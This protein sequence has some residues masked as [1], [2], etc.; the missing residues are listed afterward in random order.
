MLDL[1]PEEKITLLGRIG[2]L[3]KRLAGIKEISE[4]LLK[5]KEVQNLSPGT[6]DRIKEIRD[7]SSKRE[8]Q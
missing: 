5:R 2:R 8:D 4:D 3:L 1:G 6:R 7:I